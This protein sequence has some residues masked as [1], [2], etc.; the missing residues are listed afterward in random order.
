MSAVSVPSKVVTFY[1]KVYEVATG[2]HIVDIVRNE[3][4]K[5]MIYDYAQD[6][7]DPD[8]VYFLGYDSNE[9]EV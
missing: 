6:Q 1:F 5:K 9:Y 7:T 2:K 8:S 3:S 4:L